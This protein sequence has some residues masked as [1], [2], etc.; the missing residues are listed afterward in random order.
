MS[1]KLVECSFYFQYFRNIEIQHV[2]LNVFSKTKLT[3][4]KRN[5]NV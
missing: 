4:T 2:K 3:K 1:K 5:Y